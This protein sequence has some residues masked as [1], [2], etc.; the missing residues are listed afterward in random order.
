[1][2]EAYEATSYHQPSDEL[3]EEWNLDGLV[4]DSRLG[5]M[6]GLAIAE[7]DE[8]PVWKPGDEFEAARQEALSAL[9][10]P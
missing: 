3:T 6:V 2:V 5:F 8:P 10:E 1:M 7:T 9:R 4:E